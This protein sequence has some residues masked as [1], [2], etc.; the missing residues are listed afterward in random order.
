M[1]EGAR[2][3]SNVSCRSRRCF[4]KYLFQLSRASASNAAGVELEPWWRV[5]EP[6][7]SEHDRLVV[8]IDPA[9]EQQV[10]DIS[11]W[12]YSITVKRM[13]SGLL[14]KPWNGSEWIM[15]RRYV[16]ALPVSKGFLLTTPASRT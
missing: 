2:P 3:G 14:W 7:Q 10:I 15:F 12:T 4:C 13:I 5:P 16:A 6:T 8:H 11:E 1:A 9:L